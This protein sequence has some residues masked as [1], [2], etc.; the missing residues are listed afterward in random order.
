LLHQAIK[1]FA[2]DVNESIMI[3]DTLTD[4]MAGKAAGINQVALL[5]TGLG[6]QQQHLPN[7]AQIEPFLIY[8]D[9]ADALE[10]KI[11]E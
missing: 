9:L 2:I 6:A 1:D 11:F 8:R 10:H 3:G 4:L 5:R 7:A